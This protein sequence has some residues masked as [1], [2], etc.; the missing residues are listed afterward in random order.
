MDLN[1]SFFNERCFCAFWFLV[2]WTFWFF[3]LGNACHVQWVI[4]IV[5]LELPDLGMSHDIDNLELSYEII[6]EE[7]DGLH[8]KEIF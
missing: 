7:F 1:E 3:R 4:A 8:S 6:D 5:V 2:G